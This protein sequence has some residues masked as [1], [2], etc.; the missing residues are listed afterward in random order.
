MILSE[1]LSAVILCALGVVL[2][3]IGERDAGLAMI[4]AS[5]LVAGVGSKV[6]TGATRATDSERGA[7]RA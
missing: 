1:K 2:V 3:L 4:A 6:A 7:P 5:G